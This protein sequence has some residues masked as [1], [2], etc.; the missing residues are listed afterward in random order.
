MKAIVGKLAD[1]ES[2]V[3]LKDFMNKLGSENV[4]H[5]SSC[6][7]FSP[8]SRSSYI[9]NSRIAGVDEADLILLIGT[10]PRKES[11]VFNARLR[12]AVLNGSRVSKTIS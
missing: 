10:D 4:V 8:D 12:R 9:A 11:P 1:A 2:M 7:D 3:A 6:E 5:E